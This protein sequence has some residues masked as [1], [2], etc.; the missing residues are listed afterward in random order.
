M[1]A[2]EGEE[3]EGA[4]MV[5]TILTSLAIGIGFFILLPA[6]IAHFISNFLHWGQLWTNLFEGFIRLTLL[7]GYIWAIGFMPDIRRV[8][9]YHCAEHKT[10]HAFEAGAPL[11]IES[12]VRFPC[13]HP[14]CGTAFLLT[15]A[16]FSILIFSVLG[17]LPLLQKLVSRILLVPVLA[18]LSYEYI[19]L[20]A[21]WT[22]YAWARPLFVPNLLLQRLTTREPEPG[23][24]EV[25]IAAFKAMREK[26]DELRPVS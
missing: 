13:A 7:V 19:R 17:P 2:V 5:L 10:I 24:V 23:M 18:S 14:R 3:L 11:E 21:K 15:V 9:S 20:S 12:I 22:R 4:P 25:A 1:Q 6:S 8:F 26:E 16:A